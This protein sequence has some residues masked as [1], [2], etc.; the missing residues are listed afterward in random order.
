MTA[1]KTATNLLPDRACY[2]AR[3]H[4]VTRT[5]KAVIDVFHC[6]T[7]NWDMSL[8]PYAYNCW[9]AAKAVG[10]VEFVGNPGDRGMG[11][12]ILEHVKQ[13]VPQEPH[14]AAAIAWA[15]AL[16]ALDQTR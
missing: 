9:F 7:E 14:R 10:F 5:A 11:V 4:T 1:T 6:D 15:E 2:W 12:M 8:N 16:I 3:R 13:H